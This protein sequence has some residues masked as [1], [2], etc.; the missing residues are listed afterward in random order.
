M[1]RDNVNYLLVGCFVL[2]AIA[3]F[4]V[5]MYFV[6]GSSGPSDRY[7]AHYRNVSGI[8]FGTA[9]MYE[10]YRIG[11]VETI[12]PD[13]QSDGM[14]YKVSF[15]VERGWRIPSDSTA[16][17]VAS[18]LISAVRVEIEEGRSTEA[19]VPGSEVKGARQTD[20]FASL[21]RAASGLTNLSEEGILPMMENL[22]HRI[23]QVAEDI[24]AFRR[25]ELS[26]FVAN[27]D[28]R[29]N[30]D[31]L[32][33]AESVL[34]KLNDSATRLQRVLG[35]RNEQRIDGFLSHLD[36]MAVNMND[37][38]KRL[39]ETRVQ[40][41]H[42]LVGVDALVTDNRDDIGAAVKSARGSLADMQT[43]LATI[44]EHIDSVMYH[45]EGSTREMHEVARALREN[46]SRLIRAPATA[47][48]TP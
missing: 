28:R 23:T 5:F 33:E 36:E 22:N 30:G 7:F 27:L 1:K 34:G 8:K 32:N 12:A 9:V 17:V 41:N 13:P 21:N 44:N 42:V 19:L 11:Q 25:T 40:M 37:L 45:L 15:S 48:P 29:V 20:L 2:A 6:T 10:G 43:S 24:L 38:V 4:F 35:E 46:P 26:P 14:R 18:G 16:R 31:L 47:S 39:D 3:G